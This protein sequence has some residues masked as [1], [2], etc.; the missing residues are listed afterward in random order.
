VARR[1]RLDRLESSRPLL[2]LL[3]G[4]GPLSQPEIAK[5]LGWTAGTC[6][7]HLQR[8]EHL[9]LAVRVAKEGH[10]RGRPVVIWD[11]DRTRNLLLSASFEG[12]ELRGSLTDLAGRIV[13][14][15]REQL[16]AAAAQSAVL[17]A[18]DVFTRESLT[19]SRRA[20]GTVRQVFLALPGL[21]DAETGAV[22]QAANLPALNGLDLRSHLERRLSLP[23]HTG[24]L[25]LAYYYGEAE[26]LPAN[27]TVMVV[28]WD[29]GI[30][31][32][33]GRNEEVLTLAAG[34]DPSRRQIPELGHVRIV[35]DGYP[36]TCGNHGCLEAYAGGWALLRDLRH[37]PE[38]EGLNDLVSRGL[39]GD[40]AVLGA[41]R[42]A[43]FMLGQHLAWA[44]Q[45]MGAQQIV[46]SGPLA[47]LF[48]RVAS[49]FRRGLARTFRRDEID[50]LDPA[51]S[52]DPQGRLQRG[53][54]LLARRLFLYP[55]AAR[56]LPRAPTSLGRAGNP[57][58]TR[59]ALKQRV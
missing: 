43:A 10:G 53:A 24:S 30:G 29:L 42:R 5:R 6:S 58:T 41:V 40:R 31:V 44:I 26:V 36:C 25:G 54:F 59:K 27:T 18:L 14:A 16:R 4:A 52:P 11:L 51:A 9:G 2:H 48:E 15:H 1:L 12:T 22:L 57:R 21:L 35:R 50:R 55:D 38:R 37:L 8:L 33:F 17:D 39:E 13:H 46:V 23:C 45:V 7:L 19:H 32:V 34:A 47:P 56:I 3:E 28:H 20:R 49:D